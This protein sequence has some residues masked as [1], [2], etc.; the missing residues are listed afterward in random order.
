MAQNYI[1]HGEV[2]TLNARAEYKS[3]SPYRIHGFNG[4]ALISVVLGDLLSFK[5]Q[6]VFEFELEGV[7]CG[8]LIFIDPD[9][10]LTLSDGG[11]TYDDKLLRK[12]VYPIFGR[13]VAG[14]DGG[15]YFH[16]RILQST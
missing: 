2:I 4:V 13:A 8:D 15:K 14:S 5:L 9:N 7:K 3:G 1:S 16:C 11:F 6:G 12:T 10:N